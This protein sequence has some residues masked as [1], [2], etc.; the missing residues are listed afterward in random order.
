MTGRAYRSPNILLITCHDLGRHLGCYGIETVATP[1]L[2]RLAATGVR[3]AQAFATAPSCSP[4]RTALATGRHPHSNGVMGLTHPPFGWDL[5]PG[6]RHMAQILGEAGYHTHLFGFQ[7]VSP[8][9]DR[10][11]FA[12]IHTDHNRGLAGPVAMKVGE[13]LESWSNERPFY[14]EVNL[15]EPHRP[16]DQG[17]CVPDASLGVTV[18]G[19]LPL[20]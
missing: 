9:D 19:Y 12:Q 18:P 13:L 16:Y 5:H 10:P 17:N 7:H 3:V 20:A 8:Y 14:L 11:G 15:E 2:D 6:E 4:S 1:H